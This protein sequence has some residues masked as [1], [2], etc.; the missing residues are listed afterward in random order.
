M[1]WSQGLRHLDGSA[2]TKALWIEDEPH[3]AEDHTG[4]TGAEVNVRI[5]RALRERQGGR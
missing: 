1:A 5:Y 4:L 3:V 2:L